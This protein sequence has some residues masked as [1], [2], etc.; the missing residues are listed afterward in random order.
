MARGTRSASLMRV[1]GYEQD[2]IEV[3]VHAGGVI[4]L[5]VMPVLGFK[6]VQGPPSSRWAHLPEPTVNVPQPIAPTR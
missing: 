1:G 4:V 2:G 5:W 3:G 6:L